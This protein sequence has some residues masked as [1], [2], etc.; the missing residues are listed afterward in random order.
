MLK[1]KVV[2][3]C[4][5]ILLSVSSSALSA[6]KYL[7]WGPSYK[8]KGSSEMYKF[9][10]ILGDSYY[11]VQKPNDANIIQRFNF[12]HE[13]ISETRYNHVKNRERLKIHGGIETRKG[14]FIFSHQFNQK[15]KEWILYVSE[16]SNGTPTAPREAWFEEIDIETSRLRRAYQDYEYDYGQVDGGL[17][18][19]EDSSKVAFV[20]IIPGNDFRDEDVIAIG[21]FDDRMQLIWKEMFY[22]KFADKRYEIKQSVVTNEGEIYLVC[23]LDDPV[24][25]DGKVKSIREKNLPRFEYYL[26]HINREGILPYKVDLGRGGAPMD[27]ALFFPDRET[28]RFLMAGFYTDD[29]HR[30]RIKGMFFSYG[31]KNFQNTS[32][33]KHQFRENFLAG[34]VSDKAIQK[35]K[36]LESSYQILDV[37]NYDDGS[38][39]FIAENNY[40]RDLSQTDFYG[41]WYER[42]IYV[43]DELIIPRFN[44][45]GVL[46]NIEKIPKQ[47]DSDFAQYTS[48]AIALNKGLTYLIFNDYKSGKEKQEIAKKGRRFTDLLV[49]GQRGEIVG[50][51]TLFTEREIEL[52]FNP[53][54]CDYNDEFFL[55]G[56]KRGNKFSMASLQFNQ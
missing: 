29:E 36:G 51:Q 32:I 27:V 33:K 35:G 52:E 15:Y 39:G 43:S 16:M 47:F 55:I 25:Y 54:L 21:V 17:I 31:D 2:L 30:Y 24:E 53:L 44:S 18:M 50:H 48:Y 7:S 3:F 45:E 8:I 1:A 56:S 6:Q 37:L 34:L 19:S 26:Y 9:L 20:N 5:M 12:R 41:R 13:L 46:L 4:S 23:K 28:N 38:I 40:V 22:Y 14:S 42:V 49:L 10:G 11:F